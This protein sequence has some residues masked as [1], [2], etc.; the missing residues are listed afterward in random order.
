MQT[1]VNAADVPVLSQLLPTS[2]PYAEPK[3]H[4]NAADS[5]G[6]VASAKKT[7]DGM[8]EEAQQNARNQEK[9]TPSADAPDASAAQTERI[10]E[11]ISAQITDDETASDSNE[12]KIALAAA[13]KTEAKAAQKKTSSRESKKTNRAQVKATK[14]NPAETERSYEDI[15]RLVDAARQHTDMQKSNEKPLQGF[16]DDKEALSAE[17]KADALTPSALETHAETAALAFA[18]DIK[19]TETESGGSA[20]ERGRAT[21]KTAPVAESKITVTDLRTRNAET[22][23]GKKIAEAKTAASEIRFDGKNTAEMTFAAADNVQQNL[24]SSNAQTAS[25]AGSNFQSMLANQIQNNAAEFVKAGSIV[26]KDNDAGQ[27]KLILHPESL[28]NVKIDLQISDKVITGRITVA[29]QEAFNAFKESAESIRQAFVNSGF[30][31]AG[32]DLSMAG[33]GSFADSSGAKNQDDAGS[34]I[35]RGIAYG[36]DASAGD[37]SAADDFAFSPANSINIVA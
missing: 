19:H 18:K 1:Y 35:L 29:S 31:N 32:F 20:K 15:A 7:F 33:Q 12:K 21:K 34:R 8:I 25:A 6:G 2:A 13:K 24:T 26:L 11:N 4:A 5:T 37:D 23:S 36:A 27:I 17:E 28:G 9:A 10:A 3:N 14:T 16:L 30:E 22:E